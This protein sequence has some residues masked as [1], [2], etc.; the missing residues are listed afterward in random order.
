[1]WEEEVWPPSSPDC[2]P[3]RYFLWGEFDSWVSAKSCNKNEDLIQKIKEVMGS[4]IKNT[5]AK[6]YKSLMSG[7]EAVINADGNFD[8]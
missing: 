4:L 2:N 6:A 7:I 1:V 8:N 3:F 5:V